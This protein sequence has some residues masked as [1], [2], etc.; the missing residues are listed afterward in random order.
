LPSA[1]LTT[2]LQNHHDLLPFRRS[3]PAVDARR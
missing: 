3:H 2:N 1:D